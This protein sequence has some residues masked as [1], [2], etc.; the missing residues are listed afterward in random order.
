MHKH[1]GNLPN[2]LIH[3][4]VFSCLC[5]KTFLLQRAPV[6]CW[7]GDPKFNL[8]LQYSAE[9]P[10]RVVQIVVLCWKTIP[11]DA[12]ARFPPFVVELEA[13]INSRKLVFPEDSL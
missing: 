12:G 3:Y 5:H 10:V 4:F 7:P 8:R 2:D 6:N 1:S 9:F 13:Q 11:V